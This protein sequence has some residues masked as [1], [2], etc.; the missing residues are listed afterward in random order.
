M[1]Q[2]LDWTY[3]QSFAAVADQGSLSAAART[4]GGSQ[5]T[6]SRHISAL[7]AEL[8][9][10]LF[11]RT[12][13]GLV[14]TPTGV[15]LLQ[16]ARQMAEAASH[17]SLAAT[18]RSQAIA[19]TVR[20]TASESMAVNVLPPILTALRRAEP[21]IDIELVASDQT[22]NLLLREADIA[23]RMYRPTQADMITRKV[24]TVETGMFA[25][26][27]YLTRRGY[28]SDA[29]DL[30]EHD[31]I[32][33]DRSDQII[34]GFRELGFDVGRDFFSFRCDNQE[35]TW[36]MVVAGYGIGFNRLDIGRA[37]PS[38]VRLFEE[39]EMPQLPIWLTAHAELKT[40]AR[41]RRVYDFLAAELIASASTPLVV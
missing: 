2:I 39:I 24:G 36:R 29:A 19:G 40:S 10:R 25:S 22:D 28:P 11:D 35:V 41:V 6:M 27:D 17:L 9:L 3:L 33:H 15:D 34:A 5:P 26:Q 37:E 13:G 12:G 14:L 1:T 8:G 23:V 30:A 7:E 20:V 21:E 31:L 38:V 32:G 4:L 16:H 18:G